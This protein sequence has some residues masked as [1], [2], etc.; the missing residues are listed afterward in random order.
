MMDS[1]KDNL[2]AEQVVDKLED[3][4]SPESTTEITT[5]EVINETSNEGDIEKNHK[6]YRKGR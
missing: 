1:Q 3:L 6:R 2:S 5:T 4:A